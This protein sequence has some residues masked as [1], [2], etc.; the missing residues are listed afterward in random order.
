MIRNYLDDLLQEILISHAVT[1][2][3]VLRTE[4]SEDDGYIRIKCILVNNDILEFAEY[5]QIHK[6]KIHSETY[7]FHWQS[8]DGKL[9]KRWDNVRHHKHVDT[10]PYHVHLSDGQVIN[11]LPM[12]LTKVIQE[13]ETKLLY[14]DDIL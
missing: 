5:V 9:I 11:S 8:A 2:F 10:F 14:K 4:T 7:S 12:T 13:I 3:K 6:S 1:S